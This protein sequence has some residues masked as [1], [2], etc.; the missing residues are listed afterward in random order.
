MNYLLKIVIFLVLLSWYPFKVY[1]QK[2]LNISGFITD[3]TSGEALIGAYVYDCNSKFGTTTN[4]YGFYNLQFKQ[5]EDININ[6]SYLGY[7]SKSIKLIMQKSERLNFIISSITWID[8]VKVTNEKSI[9][10][11]NE[12]STITLPMRDMAK[13]PSLFGEADIIKTLQMMP[14]LI[15]GSE[16]NS[17]IYVRGG[18]PDQNLILLDE[19]PLYYIA[20][21]GG[22]F[23][24]FNSDILNNVVMYKGG[25]PARYGGRLSSVIDVQMKEGDSYNFHGEGSI[26]LLYSKLSLEGP[27]KKGKTSFVLSARA[28]LLPILKLIGLDYSFYDVN[29]KLNHK[30]TD[31]DR[32]YLSFYTGRDLVELN[33]KANFP[34]GT[35]TQIYGLKWGNILGTARWNHIFNTKTFSNTTFYLTKYHFTN[36]NSGKINSDS[37]STS[38]NN[39]FYNSILDYCLK[40]SFETQFWNVWSLKF[41]CGDIIH[42]FS[43][44][45]LDYAQNINNSTI[46]G[47]FAN[48]VFKS[49]E[50]Y[51][52]I[53]NEINIKNYV[54]VNFGG[55]IVDY[56]I[57]NSSFLYFE[58]RILCNVRFSDNISLKLGYSSMT[59]FIHL[60]SYTDA[61]IP[62]DFW[63]PATVYAKPEI[64][65]QIATGLSFLLFNKTFEFSVEFYYKTLNN[66]IAFRAGE[67]LYTPGNW[68]DKVENNG[69]GISHGI[70]LFLQK[71]RGQTTGWFGLTIASSTRHFEN[72]NNNH[73]FPYNY[74]RLL[75][76]NLAAV[77][78]FNDHISFSAEWTFG[79]GYPVTLPISKY[80]VMGKEVFVYS[81]INGYRMDSYHRLDVGVNFTRK[82]KWGIR[83]LNLSIYNVYNRQNPYFL[84]LQ[85]ETIMKTISHGGGISGVEVPGAMKLYQQSLFPFLPSISYSIKF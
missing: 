2:L 29:A 13:L 46:Q 84:Y 1:S 19:V 67:S 16:G 62:S 63:L 61:G 49:G 70:E 17:N 32:L 58:P 48:E 7:K 39:N 34:G 56:V 44:G 80:T 31:N 59:Q 82:I 55:R 14:G 60:L 9:N 78:N 35:S 69:I 52:Y 22:F 57:K 54:S 23:S 73:W 76:L 38:A 5:N 41:G 68:E 81:D 21:L 20:H 11:K 3:S 79:S 24:V 10:E 51:G 40:T 77:H 4:S 74:D 26:G 64:S 47:S 42:T 30:F 18:S 36:Y 50:L 75:N 71:K 72:L 65:D 43:P 15:S 8:E 85:R 83:T 37:V 12:I 66:L 53:E 45:Q 28:S 27:I 25:F 6:V 33:H